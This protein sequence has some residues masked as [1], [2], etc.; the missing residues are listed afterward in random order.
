MQTEIDR[1]IFYV[2][3]SCHILFLV[4][5]AYLG[6]RELLLIACP[7]CVTSLKIKLMKHYSMLL[8][9]SHM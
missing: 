2:V 8:Y 6:F 5:V 1:D 4:T 3:V 7:A 9:S